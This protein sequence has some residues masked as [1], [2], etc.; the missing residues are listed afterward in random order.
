MKLYKNCIIYRLQKCNIGLIFTKYHYLKIFGDFYIMLTI[1]CPHPPI[2]GSKLQE[3]KV[4]YYKDFEIHFATVLA[5]QKFLPEELQR[6][7]EKMDELIEL[8]NQCSNTTSCEVT[9]QD[10][11]LLKQVILKLR[12][13]EAR[14]IEERSLKT[15]NGELLDH[16][17]A[18]LNEFNQIMNQSWFIQAKDYRL[19]KL[20]DY[21]PIE[22]IS[23]KD[24]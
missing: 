23:V 12:L 4:D 5:L 1:P 3:F 21:F 10:A 20:S 15:F 7:F 13:K 16:L 2:I 24:Y 18:S 8:F 14:L 6:V 19:P 17:N 9:E 11:G 22:Y